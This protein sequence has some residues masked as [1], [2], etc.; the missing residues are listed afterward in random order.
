VTDVDGIG[1]LNPFRYRGYYFDQETGLYYLK[2]RYYDSETGR[3]INMDSLEKLNPSAINGLNLY[4]YC[5]NN[6]NKFH[7]PNG[8]N[9]LLL[10]LLLIG[11]GGIVGGAVINGAINASNAS[12][13]GANFWETSKAFFDE[14]WGT[15][16]KVGQHMWD[17][18]SAYG[19]QVNNIWEWLK[20]PQ[21]QTF[22]GI[23]GEALGI[24][25]ATGIPYVSGAAFLLYFGVFIIQGLTYIF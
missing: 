1:T 8:R 17:V 25:A 21:G 2:S 12:N 7:D 22:L 4:A 10:I 15:I 18:A 20:T 5:L 24:I 9:P 3:F 13:S 11:V 6:P 23:S 14:A 16:S 19:K